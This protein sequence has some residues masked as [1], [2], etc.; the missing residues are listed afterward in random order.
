MLS[1]LHPA[2][3][4]FMHRGRTRQTVRIFCVC[5]IN[6]HLV[7]F[8]MQLD[9]HALQQLHLAAL[10]DQLV[11][12]RVHDALLELARDQV[13]VVRVLPAKKRQVKGQSGIR[14]SNM[15]RTALNPHV[16]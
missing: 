15:C 1:G 12:R 2:L 11:W 13:R 5:I 14:H 3:S 6:P 8:R 16:C 9:Q 4:L 10:L 7:P